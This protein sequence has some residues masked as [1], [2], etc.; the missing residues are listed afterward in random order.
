[1]D[2][3]DNN[4]DALRKLLALKRHELPPPGYFDRLPDRIID[5]IAACEDDAPVDW[6]RSLIDHFR[7]R[8]AFLGVFSF[9]LGAF[10][11]L[12]L[13]TADRGTPPLEPAWMVDARAVRATRGPVIWQPVP[14]PTM[15]RRVGSSSVA[16]VIHAGAS[17]SFFPA[18]R[19]RTLDRI[20]R[21]SYT[22]LPR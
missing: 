8:P 22:P 14:E 9:T 4:F 10:Y 12:G 2:P 16:P 6:F 21:A 3:A 20:E 15:A 13:G 19:T 5:R 7:L 17:G 1:M 18:L 11:L